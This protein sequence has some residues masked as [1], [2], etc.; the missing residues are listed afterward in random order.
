MFFYVWTTL[1]MS[2]DED[3]VEY[4][5]QLFPSVGSRPTYS[6]VLTAPQTPAPPPTPPRLIR[7]TFSYFSEK[8]NTITS[9]EPPFQRGSP[10]ATRRPASRPTP[11]LPRTPPDHTV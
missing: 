2:T 10:S 3:R 9:L 6:P 1:S 7:A 5:G 11:P 4:E 8:N